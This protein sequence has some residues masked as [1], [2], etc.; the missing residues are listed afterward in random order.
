MKK[1]QKTLLIWMIV[2][3]SIVAVVGASWF[4]IKQMTSLNE[5]NNVDVVGKF[6]WGTLSCGL[7]PGKPYITTNQFNLPVEGVTLSDV[8]FAYTPKFT[9]TVSTPTGAIF[10]SNKALY[11][12]ICEK[13][14][15]E[16]CS[17]ATRTGID[18][19]GFSKVLPP[20]DADH[21]LFVQV[22]QAKL[23]LTCTGFFTIP[24]EKNEC[25]GKMD[26]QFGS[27]SVEYSNYVLLRTD[28][29]NGGVV[30]L[31]E[32][33]A[34]PK[35]NA[36]KLQLDLILKTNLAD[37]NAFIQSISIDR[38]KPEERW[39]Y[40]SN[41]VMAVVNLE[42]YSGQDAVCQNNIMYG[43]SEI[44][45]ISGKNYS[46]VDQSKTLGGVDCCNGDVKLNQVC[47]D[48]KF[49][50][51][52]QAECSVSKPCPLV[53][54]QI[55]TKDAYRKTLIQQNCVNGKCVLQNKT[56]E[57][58]SNIA[59]KEGYNC[60]GYKCVKTGADISPV[61]APVTITPP[62]KVCKAIW[63]VAGFTVIPNPTCFSWWGQVQL[64][65]SI[66]ITLFAFVLTFTWLKQKFPAKNEKVMLWVLSLAITVIFGILTWLLFWTALVIFIIY[67]IIRITVGILLKR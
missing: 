1:S 8:N 9:V 56:V 46:V 53:D 45:T 20:V 7:A 25:W 44:S 30:Q 60:V 4:G 35:T 16:I 52:D 24:Y 12:K 17:Y 10:S 32:T 42:T 6:F 51:L 21:N 5:S 47:K 43:L 64:V 57:C 55:D 19:A 29:L 66:L 61:P 63:S 36:Q 67:V 27:Y 15:P 18:R 48:H 54:W 11:Y 37:K 39:N 40:V 23:G 50:S 41:I 31:S 3:V 65:A 62:E 49:V 34:N 22:Q 38:L 59:C 28:A 13:A 58:T 33:C 14:H 26:N 2:L